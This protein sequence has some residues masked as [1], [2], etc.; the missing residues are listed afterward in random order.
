[1]HERTPGRLPRVLSGH[2]MGY[3]RY[4]R[5]P[6]QARHSHLWRMGA[7]AWRRANAR[8]KATVAIAPIKAWCPNPTHNMVTTNEDPTMA[9]S[10][11][12]ERF[13]GREFTGDRD[14]VQEAASPLAIYRRRPYMR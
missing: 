8:P 6:Q 3:A 9:R 5:W 10:T 7:C 2:R 14:R 12:V 13:D 11:G 1:M 4:R